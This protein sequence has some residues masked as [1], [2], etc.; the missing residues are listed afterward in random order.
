MATARFNLDPSVE[1]QHV[2]PWTIIF[3]RI[4][5]RR[6]PI[7]SGDAVTVQRIGNS[8]GAVRIAVELSGLIRVED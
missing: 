3:E 7:Q 5:G 4:T 2:G 6:D 8:S 1:F